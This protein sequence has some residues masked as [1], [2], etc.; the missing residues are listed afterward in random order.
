MEWPKLGLVLSFFMFIVVKFYLDDDH[1][2]LTLLLMLVVF[3]PFLF[4]LVVCFVMSLHCTSK[5]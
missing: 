2:Q 3:P 1:D 5:I 4:K